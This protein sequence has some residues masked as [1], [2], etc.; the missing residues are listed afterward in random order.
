MKEQT[1]YT[2][3]GERPDEDVIFAIK[4]HPW[5]L[6]KSGFVAIGTIILLILFFLF[7]G[8]SS[9]TFGLIIALVCFLILYGLYARFVYNNHLYF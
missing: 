9:F 5:I 1:E 7:F 2:F 6:A 8:F 4:R 3:E